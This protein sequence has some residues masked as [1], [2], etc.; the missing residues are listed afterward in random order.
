MGGCTNN[1]GQKFLC[2][3]VI[4]PNTRVMSS[5][6]FQVYGGSSSTAVKNK[7]EEEEKEQRCPGCVIQLLGGMMLQRN[8]CSSTVIVSLFLLPRHNFRK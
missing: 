8:L 5:H 6:A 4:V 7:R 2:H 1:N 3:V